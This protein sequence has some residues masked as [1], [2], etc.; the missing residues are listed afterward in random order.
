MSQVS[1][2]VW[3][4]AVPFFFCCSGDVMWSF[5]RI[6]GDLV[7]RLSLSFVRDTQS[8][9][10]SVSS[11]YQFV[12]LLWPGDNAAMWGLLAQLMR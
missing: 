3:A 1:V 9:A 11:V 4:P 10:S 8:A 5:R 6:K 7:R 12:L 2:H